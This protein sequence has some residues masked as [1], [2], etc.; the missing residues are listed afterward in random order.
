MGDVE[1]ICPALRDRLEGL[2]SVPPPAELS[3]DICSNGGVSILFS[4]LL[5]IG[6]FFAVRFTNGETWGSIMNNPLAQF[7][8]PSLRFFVAFIGSLSFI[9]TAPMFFTRYNTGRWIGKFVMQQLMPDAFARLVGCEPLNGGNTTYLLYPLAGEPDDPNA[10]QV[11]EFD[12][13]R[14]TDIAFLPHASFGILW[15]FF[16]TI[17]I[18]LATYA[19]VH[20]G[21]PSFHKKLG[22]F[23]I[24]IFTCHMLGATHILY[25]N[26]VVS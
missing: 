18:F 17:H 3:W 23:S 20:V 6:F 15:D 21:N 12:Y 8:P 5:F 4:F 16:G 9:L 1:F 26:V 25:R 22:Y 13:N 7:V 14:W 11:E 10:N 2:E 24:C 19:S